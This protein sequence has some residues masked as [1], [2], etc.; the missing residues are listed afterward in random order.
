[1]TDIFKRIFKAALFVAATLSLFA[2]L[3]ERE[4]MISIEDEEVPEETELSETDGIL[5]VNYKGNA[6]ISYCR[7]E[8]LNKH[9]ATYLPE[10]LLGEKAGYFYPTYLTDPDKKAGM[11]CFFWLEGPIYLGMGTTFELSVAANKSPKTKT[12]KFI[13]P[14]TRRIVREIKLGI[15]GTD[16]PDKDEKVNAWK[17]VVKDAAGKV[18]TEKHSWLW[19]IK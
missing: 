2:C 13:V 18:I 17:L 11:Y 5:G 9:R 10:K 7:F 8:Y 12:Y 14:E 4:R 16:W 19:S 3:P 1:M 6:Q 15:T